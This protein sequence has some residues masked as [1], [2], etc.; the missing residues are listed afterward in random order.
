M[1][2][3][4]F[5]CILSVLTP[6]YVLVWAPATRT[7]VDWNF[8]KFLIGTLAPHHTFSPAPHAPTHSRTHTGR[9]GLP[10]KRWSN[11]IA[12]AD[13]GLVGSLVLTLLEECSLNRLLT[14]KERLTTKQ[15]KSRF[16]LTTRTR[17]H[18]RLCGLPKTESVNSSQAQPRVFPPLPYWC[19]S[20]RGLLWMRDVIGSM[21]ASVAYDEDWIKTASGRGSVLICVAALSFAS[22]ALLSMIKL[23]DCSLTCVRTPFSLHGLT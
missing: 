6:H 19:R 15:P 5:F 11:A 21:K 9:N 20:A 23:P 18:T 13:P 3:R 2:M 8:E 7:D 10:I 4:K 22:R 16:C 12:T 17:A 14:S 1:L